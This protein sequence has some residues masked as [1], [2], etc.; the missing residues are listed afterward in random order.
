MRRGLGRGRLLVGLGAVV[1]IV[2]CFLPWTYVRGDPGLPASTENAFA[3]AG[4]ITF[5]AAVGLLALLLLPYASATGRSSLDRWPS[6]VLV[7]GLMVVGTVVQVLQLVPGGALK[8]TPPLDVLGLYLGII[9]TALVA[10]GVAEIV[11]ESGA[12]R[13]ADGPRHMTTF[14]PRG[15]R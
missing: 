1:A 14:K 12:E 15:R 3:G 4:V 10:W 13:R 11:S 5:I 7:G 9:G 8:L 2:G 6:Y